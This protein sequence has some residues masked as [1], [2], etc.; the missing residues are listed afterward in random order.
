MALITGHAACA[1]S[2]CIFADELELRQSATL[3]KSVC[4]SK[5]GL[6]YQLTEFHFRGP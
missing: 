3:R 2:F 5:L 6:M 4:G 1:L